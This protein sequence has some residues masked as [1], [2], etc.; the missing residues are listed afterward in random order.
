MIAMTKSGYI[1]ARVEPELKKSAEDILRK[2]GVST[3]DAISMF[4]HQ[5]VLQ[6]GLPFEARLPN[7][8]TQEAVRELESGGGETFTGST[9][10]FIAHLAGK[11]KM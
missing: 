10:E 5:V 7:K 1:S 8:K 4:L 11:R 2:V 9:R 6:R 3:S